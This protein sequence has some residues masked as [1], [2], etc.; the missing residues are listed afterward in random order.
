[1][2]IYRILLSLL[3]LLPMKTYSDSSEGPDVLPKFMNGNI[4]SFMTWIVGHAKYPWEMYN[5]GIPGGVLASFTINTDGELTDVKI[6]E[7]TEKILADEIVN[8]LAAS[9]KWEPAY[10]NGKPVNFHYTVPFLFYNPNIKMR[11]K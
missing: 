10:K 7:Y 3:C 11:S 1:M 6:L 2:K 4:E 5:R 8:S 9:P